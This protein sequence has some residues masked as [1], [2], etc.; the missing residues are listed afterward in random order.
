MHVADESNVQA[1]MPNA[2]LRGAHQVDVPVNASQGKIASSNSRHD[3]GRRVVRFSGKPIAQLGHCGEDAGE[4]GSANCHQGAEG[5]VPFLCS[6]APTENTDV[7]VNHLPDMVRRVSKMKQ[8]SRTETERD[9]ARRFGTRLFR[10]RG[11][12]SRMVLLRK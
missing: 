7:P 4:S 9:K 6:F 3:L 2:N 11:V 5:T 10:L 12:R 8:V 1:P